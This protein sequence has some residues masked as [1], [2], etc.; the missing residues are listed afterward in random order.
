MSN[1]PRIDYWMLPLIRKSVNTQMKKET[2]KYSGN[3][4]YIRLSIE[5]RNEYNPIGQLQVILDKLNDIQ[6]FRDN[7]IK[8]ALGYE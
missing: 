4:E 6:M 8:E 7:R 1:E 3:T 2:S 5:K